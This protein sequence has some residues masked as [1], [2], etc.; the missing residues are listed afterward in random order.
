MPC[1]S[2]LGAA[3]DCLLLLPH[4]L[5]LPSPLPSPPA[6]YGLERMAQEAVMGPQGIFKPQQPAAAAAGGSKKHQ[7][8]AAAAAGAESAEEAGEDSG[9]DLPPEDS[10]DDEEGSDD[11]AEVP[12]GSSSGGWNR[13]AAVGA[14]E[15]GPALRVPACL[16]A[17]LPA[18]ASCCHSPCPHHSSFS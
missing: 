4:L 2:Q 8:A 18:V 3:S 5:L 7:Q 17:C 11:E 15:S 6:D 12:A 14:C 1:R 10:E 16:P 13:P 9:S